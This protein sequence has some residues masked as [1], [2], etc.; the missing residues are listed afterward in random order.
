M[1]WQELTEKLK[2]MGVQ[3]GI[4][5]KP[6]RPLKKHRDISQLLTGHE[7]KT[8]Y[9]SVF[10]SL[11]HY[12]NSYQHG[13]QKIVP[14][15][16]L[17]KIAS[18]AR[19]SQ[20]DQLK[21]EDLVFLDTETTGLSGGTGTIAFMVGAARFID[22]ELVLEQFFLRNPAEETAM[23]TALA[24][25]CDGM[26]GIVTYNG[27]SFD[28]PILNTRFILQGMRSPFID[29][30]HYD[31]LHLT[32]RI[33]RNR[34]AQCNLGNIEQQI[35]C[36]QRNDSEIPGYLVPEFYNQ[37]LR[38]GNAEPLVGVFYHNKVDVI[39]LAALF[40]FFADLFANPKA[41]ETKEIKDLT[42]VGRLIE[43]LGDSELAEEIYI[44]GYHLDRPQEE[45]LELLL[46]KARLHKRNGQ[47]HLALPLWEE[48]S[49]IGSLDALLEMAKYHEHINKNFKRAFEICNQAIALV[50]TSKSLKQTAALSSWQHRLNRL[51]ARLSK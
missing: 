49:Q 25:F 39:S 42:S 19:S 40:A 46:R 2:R 43:S 51:N 45:R 47:Y 14:S 44:K 4:E 29:L 36:L 32:R 12:P 37:Y 26:R 13:N 48:A 31:L 10:S 9:G 6:D 30:P 15:L 28:I 22:N 33:W 20:P 34:L 24:E 27:K 35:L 21:L 23:V 50:S 3:V 38:D 5:K 1:D 8:I 7:I 18:W 17:T 41:W 11:H 16:Q